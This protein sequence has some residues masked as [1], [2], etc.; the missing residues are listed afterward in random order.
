MPP[1]V[2]HFIA[3]CLTVLLV[4]LNDVVDA[5]RFL[6]D[7]CTL[8]EQREDFGKVG[9]G[10]EGLDVLEELMLWDANERVFD[11]ACVSRNKSAG[12]YC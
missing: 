10:R 6:G 5:V 3:Q 11:P 8:L 12:W 9:P 4:E 2:G 1:P 7:Q